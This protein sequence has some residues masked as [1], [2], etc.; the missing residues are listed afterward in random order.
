MDFEKDMRLSWSW[1]VQAKTH[2][3]ALDVAIGVLREK[4]VTDPK[5]SS[6]YT[7]REMTPD[8]C[9]ITG[10]FSPYQRKEFVKSNWMDGVYDITIRWY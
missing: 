1:C 4:L 2:G 7:T 6:R 10:P 9:T 3:E 5:T 8:E